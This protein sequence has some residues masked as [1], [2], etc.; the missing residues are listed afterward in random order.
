MLLCSGVYVEW[1]MFEPKTEENGRKE[2]I[3]LHNE[4]LHNL[5]LLQII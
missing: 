3:T 1:G 2:K 5:N 4:M